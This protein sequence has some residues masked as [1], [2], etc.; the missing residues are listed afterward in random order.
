MITGLLVGILLGFILQ[1]A[2]FCMTGGFRDIYLTKS[3]TML[4]ADRKSTRLNSSHQ[5]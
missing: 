5:I 2:R 3:F 4:Y 1:R